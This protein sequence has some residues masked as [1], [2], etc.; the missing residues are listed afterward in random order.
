MTKTVRSAAIAA[1]T[2]AA[3]ALSGCGSTD[4]TAAVQASVD[5]LQSR[6]AVLESAQ[7]ESESR[8]QVL[9]TSSA[10]AATAESTTA[11]TSASAAGP[12]G[13]SAAPTS[14]AASASF[15]AS[16][17]RTGPLQMLSGSIDLDAPASAADW[18]GGTND[19]EYTSGALVPLSGAQMARLG[20][21]TDNQ[22]LIADLPTCSAATYS[23][24]PIKTIDISQ[25][26]GICVKTSDGRF[27]ALTVLQAYN[28]SFS[29]TS[30]ELPG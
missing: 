30:Y 14:P 20:K 6:V 22:S 29:A 16:V 23:T 5:A 26:D 7:A 27:A 18:S 19:I 21:G 4:D 25:G 12:T 10:T 17:R 8:A 28:N 2:L 13:P 1:A 3:I 24:Q 11:S 15:E 9:A